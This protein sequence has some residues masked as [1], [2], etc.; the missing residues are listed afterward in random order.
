MKNRLVPEMVDRNSSALVGRGDII[1]RNMG[2]GLVE[3]WVVGPDLW[4]AGQNH[5]GLGEQAGPKAFPGVQ[6]L[7]DARVEEL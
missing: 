4:M 1:A 7:F 5:G 3:N 2:D 6:V